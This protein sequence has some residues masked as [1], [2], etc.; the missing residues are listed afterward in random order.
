MKDEGGTLPKRNFLMPWNHIGEV[1]F[2][3]QA[4]D[5]IK[6]NHDNIA[7]IEEAAVTF[8]GMKYYG[9]SIW[10]KDDEKEKD[11]Q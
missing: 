7:Y 2:N 8:Y 10:L 6:V 3:Q 1:P 9:I 4:D 5:F 11:S